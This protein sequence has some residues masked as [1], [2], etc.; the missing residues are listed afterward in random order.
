[1]PPAALAVSYRE[2][3]LHAQCCE[4]IGKLLA[5]PLIGAMMYC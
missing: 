3:A 1:M 4:V 5:K 2:M